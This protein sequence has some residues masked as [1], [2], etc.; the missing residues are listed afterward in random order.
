MKM[1]RRTR[2]RKG[3]VQGHRR[4]PGHRIRGAYPQGLNLSGHT[5]NGA[6]TL[7]AISV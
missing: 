4:R 5:S 2:R 1:H 7:H 3:E 6:T